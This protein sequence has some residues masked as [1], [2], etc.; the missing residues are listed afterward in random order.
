MSETYTEEDLAMLSA[1]ERAGIEAKEEEGIDPAILKEVAGEGEGLVVSPAGPAVEA[2][3]LEPPKV[4][5]APEPVAEPSP[6][7]VVEPEPKAPESPAVY[8]FD[9][10][11][12]RYL[13]A[14]Q[15]GENESALAIRREIRAEEKK[16]NDFNNEVSR[17][18]AKKAD[19]EKARNNAFEVDKKNY[20]AL[21]NDYIKKYPFLD[22]LEKGGNQEAVEEVAASTQYQ[23]NTYG[24]SWTEALKLSVEKIAPRYTG[25]P[26]IPTPTP[27]RPDI[28]TLANV[29]VVES[30]NPDNGKWAALDKLDG[31][32]YEAAVERLTPSER[33]EYLSK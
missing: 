18:E 4:E 3:A 30:N 12:L 23:V 14:S 22:K 19:I 1:E 28:K 29:P 11:E 6:A 25:T 24:K 32:A 16:V 5:V 26:A 7:I 17:V 20:V 33:E 21:A 27:T 10:A 15:D 13:Q 2:A 8:D 31:E 9:A